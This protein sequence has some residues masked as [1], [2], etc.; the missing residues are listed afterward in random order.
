MCFGVQARTE[1]FLTVRSAPPLCLHLLLL[2]L[3]LSS[4][5]CPLLVVSG[6]LLTAC[7]CLWS[8]LRSDLRESC[9]PI[10]RDATD[11]H[12]SLNLRY[13]LMDPVHCQWFWSGASGN[14]GFEEQYGRCDC[15]G[16]RCT[17]DAKIPDAMAR[18]WRVCG[19]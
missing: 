19:H 2:R 13:G 5:L 16:G 7:G 17:C 1:S 11:C 8:L 18:S 10:L 15:T 14:E 6:R 3:P 12:I 4:V 9:S